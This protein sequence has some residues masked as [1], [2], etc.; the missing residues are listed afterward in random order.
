[1]A[2]HLGAEGAAPDGY[3]RAGD[4]SVVERAACEAAPL[5]LAARV[6]Q[7]DFALLRYDSDR[8]CHVFDAAAVCFSFDRVPERLGQR[9][10]AVHERVGNYE[11]DLLT[12]VDRVVASLKPGRPLYRTNWALAWSGELVHGPGR[13]PWREGADS[14]EMAEV[15]LGRMEE[16]GVG[17]ALHLK[18]E[19][20]VLRRLEV[21]ADAVLFTVRTLVEPLG[22]SAASS[23]AAA[24]H[25]ATQI[26]R[27]PVSFARYKGLSDDRV[28]ARVLAYLAAH[29]R[30]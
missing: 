17:G 30:T 26:A 23:P 24:A 16:L 28:R 25:L 14:A 4:G 18:V 10:A 9:M 8:G 13:Y 21:H 12:P 20:Q 1:M 6:A 15:A 3:A 27:L 11:E 29:A 7:E 2:R 19:Y 5:E 22:D